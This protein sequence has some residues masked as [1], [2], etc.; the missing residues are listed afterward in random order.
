MSLSLDAEDNECAAESTHDSE[1]LSETDSDFQDFEFQDQ[2]QGPIQPPNFE[3][4]GSGRGRCSDSSSGFTLVV[5]SI[6]FLKPTAWHA[7]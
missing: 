1:L 6:V 2:S 7:I 3:N 5:C 4:P